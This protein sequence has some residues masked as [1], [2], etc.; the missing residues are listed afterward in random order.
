MV[1]C[2]ESALKYSFSATPILGKILTVKLYYN[3]IL[4]LRTGIFSI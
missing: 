1:L 4:Q 2:K 3:I